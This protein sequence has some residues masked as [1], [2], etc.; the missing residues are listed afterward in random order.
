MDD[1]LFEQTEDESG[2]LRLHTACP[3]GHPTIQARTSVEW[4]NGLRAQSLT[5]ECLWCGDT[6]TPNAAQCAMI[7]DDVEG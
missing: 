5:F 3:A 1:D 2:R 7:L 6:W 4:Q